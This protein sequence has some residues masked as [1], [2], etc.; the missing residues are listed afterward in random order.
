MTHCSSCGRFVGPYE[1]C[2]YCGARQT[3]RLSLRAVK[4]TAILLATAGLFFLWI[5]ATRA[6]LPRISVQQ[7]TSTMN[8]A[9]VEIAGRVVRRPIY[10]PDSRFLSF[11]VD[12]GTGLMRVWAFRDVVEK[13]RAMQRIPGLGDSVI[14]AGTLRAREDDISL[15]LNVP[16]HLDVLRPVAEDRPIGDI[17]PDDNLRRVRVRGQ[18]WDIR[19]PYPALTII[20]LRDA[21]GAI[22][23]AIDETLR[24]L[25]GDPHPLEIGQSVEVIATVSLYRN[26]PQLAPPSARDVAPISEM[27]TVA[28][29]RTIGGLTPDD[30][31]CMVTIRG[32]VAQA[33]PFSAGYRLT[34]DDGTGSVTVVLW[35]D[36]YD[37]LPDP[38]ALREGAEIEVTGEVTR[39]RDELE[40]IPSRQ[41]DV[42]VQTAAPEVQ[43]LPIG[44]LADEPLGS[45]VT[46]EG[47]IVAADS[48]RQGFRLT[49]SDDTGQVI[50]LL[51]L[52][53][54]DKMTDA[55]NLRE[56]ALVR[57]TGT[58][59]EYE[60]Q[61]EVIPA[62]SEDVVITA[63]GA[64]DLP[65]RPISSLGAADVGTVVIVEGTVT[66]AEPFSQGYRAWIDDGSGEV[67]LLL[68]ENIY[69]RVPGRDRLVA[70]ASVRATGV[71]E[72]YQGTLEIIPRLPGE[73]L[74]Q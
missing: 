72:E 63:P 30:K 34:L 54:Y 39:Y 19:E 40:V 27:V 24:Y 12:D 31:G 18:I 41:R 53:V 65:T 55:H 67:M 62:H 48:F 6:P 42:V 28:E 73:V 60:G 58:L 29:T 59:E 43:P 10:N 13:L 64:T 14:I 11:A 51:W 25:T 68:W 37:S 52:S 57:A 66:R 17:T 36:L 56:G 23:V 4:W 61:R 44:T 3:P 45:P 70:G 26:A 69:R 8:F 7:A 16:D 38:S 49:L 5:A 21:T 50:L 74:I 47:A 46:V 71:V 33:R 20:T 22:D 1:T 2:P 35:R 15:T 9:Y 32:T